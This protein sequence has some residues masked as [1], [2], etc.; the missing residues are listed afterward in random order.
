MVF[1]LALGAACTT[2]VG[3]WV[4]AS[5]AKPKLPYP[6]GPKGLPFIGN[7]FDIGPQGLQHTYAQWSKIYGDI[8]YTRTFGQDVI[9]V[10]SEKTARILADGR[11][12][13]YS[14]RYS[15][16]IYK[17]FGTYRMTFVLEYGK[18][19]KTHRRLFNLSLRND[20]V[21]KYNDLHLN[22]ARQLSENIL[23]DSTNF[24]EHVDLY[25]GAIIIELMYG[26]RVE[27]KDDPAFAMASG[28]AEILRREA[29]PDRMGLLK[30]MPFLL[31]LPSWFPGAGFK[32]KAAHCRRM[33]AEMVDL[34]FAIAKDE[35]ERGVLPHCMI[36]DILK[37]RE[38]GDSSAKAAVSG[39]YLAGTETTASILKT[40]VLVMI[41]YPDV[42]EKV[43]A[44]LDTV[45]GRGILPTFA[46]KLRLPYLQ[47]VLYE[48]MRWN[49][50]APLGLPHVTTTSDIYEGY[51][52][53]KRTVVL[54]NYWEMKAH[55]YN[56]PD[57]FDPTRH[58]TPDGQL[59]PEAKQ[60]N[61]LF[62]GL[63][64]RVC[65]GRFFADHSLWAAIAVMMSSLKFGKAKD[66]SGKYIEV[67]PVFPNGLISC[68]APFPC[69]V[70]S[71][72]V[73]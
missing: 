7:A 4:L 20:I 8:V 53:P 71:R 9:V 35:M 56:D 12:E 16:P 33:A 66:S 45:V 58:L 13:I 24:F 3:L 39:L 28:V 67:E 26:R 44:E 34:P 46:D 38:V 22:H 49:P 21:G 73:E 62:Y 41:L 40:V 42:Q 64:K 52:I 54:F 2:I 63:G 6:P 48:V 43:H 30:V 57:R 5:R 61:S 50:P 72:L 11:S 36:S 69:S 27:G 51:Y 70:T 55:G 10:N 65:P 31:Y 25:A 32:R 60:N 15:S 17:D 19:W 59:S 37:N 1:L 14:D 29:T 23:C 68:P 47:A 18:E